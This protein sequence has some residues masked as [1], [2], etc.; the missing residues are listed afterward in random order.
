MTDLLDDDLYAGITAT[1][2]SMLV[3][4]DEFGVLLA[5][6]PSALELVLPGAPPSIQSAVTQAVSRSLVAR[7]AVVAEDDGSLSTIEPWTSLVGALTS[8]PTTCRITSDGDEDRAVVICVRDEDVLS[9]ELDPIRVNVAT[10]TGPGTG[11]EQVIARIAHAEGVSSDPAIAVAAAVELRVADLDAGL[12]ALGASNLT[13]AAETLG[14]AYEP[15]LAAGTPYRLQVLHG[16]SQRV[17]GADLEFRDASDLGWVAIEPSV[18]ADTV[19]VRQLTDDQLAAT[20]TSAL[21][22]D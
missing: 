10:F 3:T 8:A 1:A 2:Y 5:G 14:A 7:R 16:T 12:E 17:R 13:L 19:T 22:A 15:L 9:V 20:I 21:T 4:D 18:D 6:A 11:A